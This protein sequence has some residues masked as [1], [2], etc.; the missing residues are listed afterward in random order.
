MSTSTMITQNPPINSLFAPRT[1]NTS[2]PSA[3]PIPRIRPYKD[4]LTAALHRRF[5]RA[6]GITFTI[7]WLY[8]FIFSTSGSLIWSWFPLGPA[9]I[10]ALLLF[11]PC[12]AV[13]IVRV[14]NMHVATT[15]GGLTQVLRKP[16]TTL[17]T[18]GWYVWSAWFY[19]EIFIWT[20]GSSGSIELGWVDPGRSGYERPRMNENP[21]FLRCLFVLMGLGQASLHLSRD[22]DAIDLSEEHGLSRRRNALLSY[23]G[24]QDQTLDKLPRSARVLVENSGLIADRAFKLVFCGT[25][26]AHS[27]F[28]FIVVRRMAWRW[29]YAIGRT[30]F[31]ELPPTSPPT[32]LVNLVRLAWQAFYSSLLLVAIWEV[33]NTIFDITV[34]QP[35]TKKGEP[36]TSEIKDARGAVVHRSA[37]PN[38]SLLNGLKAKREIPKAFAFWE[39]SLISKDFEARRRSIYTDVDRR[40][41]STW[42]QICQVCLSEIRAIKE[43]ITEANRPALSSA[44]QKEQELRRQQHEHLIGQEVEEQQ[45][46]GLRKIAD[47]PV[48]NDAAV[49]A[50]GSNGSPFAVSNLARSIGQSPG[51]DAALPVARKALQWSADRALSRAD[52][53]RLAKFGTGDGFIAQQSQGYILQFLRSPPGEPFRKT[54]DRQVAGVILGSGPAT[55]KR[56]I[57]YASEALTQL[58]MCSLVEDSYGSVAK[59][60]P[61]IVRTLTEV[62]DAIEKYVGHE[63]KAH[64]T[65]VNL[66]EEARWQVA[67][68]AAEVLQVLRSGLERIVL[69]FG[70]YAGSI[71]LSKK[72]VR[73]AREAAVGSRGGAGA[74]P[75]SKEKAAIGAGERSREVE[76]RPEMEETAS[77]R[78]RN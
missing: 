7:C 43:R 51:S 54:F 67:T 36:L 40:D 55:N 63:A 69:A 33:S 29:T 5:V 52:Q 75:A 77:R 14:A 44:Q 39:L 24:V 61:E 65:D 38:G 32:G 58:V 42:T 21:I 68:E 22:Y 41:G 70:E 49:F 8:S 64:W 73:E 13:F 46:V 20:R 34:P 47:R 45:I 76:R 15:S 50:R 18:V 1:T 31:R 48:V 25:V 26:M 71:G 6:A 23:L 66:R 60:V 12:L 28:Y 11:A 37:D 57:I 72:E 78:R 17:H 35:P 4:F 56:N 53:E 2:T 62:I 3:T 27:P 9:G 30:I 16:G 19:G 59:D 74:L 10:R